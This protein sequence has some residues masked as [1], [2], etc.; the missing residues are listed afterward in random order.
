MTDDTLDDTIDRVAGEMTA[1]AADPTLTARV[2]ERIHQRRPAWVTPALAA[3]S[4]VGAVG[5]T[6][7][8]WPQN[9]LREAAASELVASAVAPIV[10]LPGTVPTELTRPQDLEG[11]TLVPPRPPPPI[12]APASPIVAVDETP[13]AVAALVVPPLV[14]PEMM[15]IEPLHIASLQIAEIEHEDPK[16][17]R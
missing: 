9:E 5:I 2:R 13:L 14:M 15:E 8:L 16:E 6:I 11:G 10:A 7:V 12:V 17:P 1:G 3:A 4:V